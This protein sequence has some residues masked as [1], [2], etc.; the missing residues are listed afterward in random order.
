MYVLGARRHVNSGLHL[1]RCGMQGGAL[2]VLWSSCSTLKEQRGVSLS[3]LRYLLSVSS[4]HGHSPRCSYFEAHECH[5]SPLLAVRPPIALV[6]LSP[7]FS[8]ELLLLLL[9][10]RSRGN[11]H[12]GTAAAK[13]KASS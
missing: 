9:L 11:T 13:H 7:L 12:F 5:F 4:R 6:L 2:G 1:I 8:G 10:L 3:Q